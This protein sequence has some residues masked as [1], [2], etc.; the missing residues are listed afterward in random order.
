M[1]MFS[2]C[3]TDLSISTRNAQVEEKPFNFLNIQSI[4]KQAIQSQW[5]RE[6]GLIPQVR[7]QQL[8]II[9]PL[10][11]NQDSNHS[12]TTILK[13]TYGVAIQPCHSVFSDEQLLSG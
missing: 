6:V 7:Q 8:L 5:P 4:N 2:V 3:R 1:Q 9:V 12:K 10:S 11:T 13:T